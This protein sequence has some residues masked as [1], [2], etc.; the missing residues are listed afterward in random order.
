MAFVAVAAA[1]DPAG[2]YPDAP[3]GPGLTIDETFNVQEG[4]RLVEGLRAWA[5][6]LISGE[7]II[8][9]REI[10]GD[11][12]DI[13]GQAP[14]GYHL[15]DHPPLGRI[16]LGLWHHAAFTA[17][18]PAAHQGPDVTACA[19]VGSAAAFAITVFLCGWAAASWYGPSAGLFASLS[20]VLMPRVFGHAHIAALETSIGL[21]YFVAVL[22]VART[23]NTEAAPSTKWAALAGLAFGAALLTKIQ[24]ILIPIP[25]AAWALFHWRLRAIRPL[26]I[27][28]AVGLATFFLLWPW[29]WFAPFHHFLEYLG[30]TTNRTVLYVWYF[31][32]RYADR[33]VPWHYPAV[34]F[35]ATVPVGLQLLG[36]LGL[37]TGGLVSGE[38]PPWRERHGQLLLAALC[39]PLVLFSLP[40]IAVYD[41][42]RLFLIVFPLWAVIVGRGG[43]FAWAWLRRRCTPRI[44]ALVAGSFLAGQA[45]GLVAVWPC[46]LS[47]YNAAVGGLRGAERLG[48]E[49]DYW[50][51]AVTRDLLEQVVAKVPDGAHIDVAPVVHQFQLDEMRNQSPVLRRR[52]IVLHAYAADAPRHADYL[53]VFRRMADLPPPLR[54]LFANAAP[55]AEVGR[56]GVVLAAFYDRRGGSGRPTP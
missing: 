30:R 54:E 21:A 52:G 56:R 28:G 31:G 50:G 53:L 24:G 37:L 11:E 20:L 17:A 12:R 46:F 39:F 26:A 6:G 35:L 45:W 34:L 51:E 40:G 33:D 25:L 5:L 29:L 48:L 1:I 42:A 8:S 23:W 18:R 27:W 14:I 55:T 15:H 44:A 7:S 49:L 10:F 3:E 32:E 2:D 9:L 36:G 43:A 16:W 13:K 22:V 19:R 38:K 47:Y 41:G 4:V